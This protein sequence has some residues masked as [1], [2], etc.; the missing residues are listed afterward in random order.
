MHACT[1]LESYVLCSMRERVSE[2]QPLRLRPEPVQ[3]TLQYA[4]MLLRRSQRL[5]QCASVTRHATIG[6]VTGFVLDS[7]SACRS[8]TN[9]LCACLLPVGVC[10]LFISPLLGSFLLLTP[11]LLWQSIDAGMVPVLRHQTLSSS[12]DLT[13]SID[14]RDGPSQ[15]CRR[16]VSVPLK[17]LPCPALPCQGHL[18]WAAKSRHSVFGQDF[19]GI[20]STL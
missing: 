2:S 14:R 5:G 13:R 17:A 15:I 12:P 16:H 7:W 8:P 9:D 11:L 20:V 10:R 6:L 18:C 4:Q 1:E 3:G 19:V